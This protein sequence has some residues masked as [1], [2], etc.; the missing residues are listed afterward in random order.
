MNSE[1]EIYNLNIRT[2]FVLI[3]KVPFM[4]SC[5]EYYSTEKHLVRN[6]EYDKEFYLIVEGKDY[7]CVLKKILCTRLS[8]MKRD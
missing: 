3:E 6:W 5:T 4:V 8:K 7:G 1:V 2:R